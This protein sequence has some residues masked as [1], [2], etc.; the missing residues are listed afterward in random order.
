[1][2]YS[3]I[4]CREVVEIVTDYLE[5]AL[6]SAEQIDLE[7][8]LAMCAGCAVYIEQMRATIRATGALHEEDV[9]PEVMDVVVRAFRSRQ[10]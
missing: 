9:P 8:H 10:S 1:M 5:G 3:E 6:A 2:T 4:E 7:R